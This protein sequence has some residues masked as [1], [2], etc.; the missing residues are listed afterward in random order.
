MGDEFS[1]SGK[2]SLSVH[3]IGTAPFAKVTIIRDGREVYVNEAKTREVTFNWLDD[4]A[5]S[6]KTSWYYVRGE[7]TDGQLVWASPM[8]IA[9]K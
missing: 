4:T 6:G 1:V 3:L 8:W 5:Q 2:P 9:V 7:Q